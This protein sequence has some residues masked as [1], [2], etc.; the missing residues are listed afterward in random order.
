MAEQDLVDKL[1]LARLIHADVPSNDISDITDNLK[2]LQFEDALSED[3]HNLIYIR[4]KSHALTA[5]ICA[6]IIYFV[7]VLNDA[8]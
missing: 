7:T 8:R 3:E 5:T 1:K 4:K 2:S 6:Q